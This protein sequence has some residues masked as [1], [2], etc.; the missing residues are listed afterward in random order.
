MQRKCRGRKKK[1]QGWG[2]WGES[3]QKEAAAVGVSEL[4]GREMKNVKDR[5]EGR[6]TGERGG[7]EEELEEE[8]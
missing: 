4:R 1:S 2:W 7:K 8:M 6:G 5:H 3:E